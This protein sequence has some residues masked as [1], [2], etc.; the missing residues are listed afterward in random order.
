MLQ[1]FSGFLILSKNVKFEKQ[2]NKQTKKLLKFFNTF[3]VTLPKFQK[4]I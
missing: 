4:I 2:N 1:L 3:K